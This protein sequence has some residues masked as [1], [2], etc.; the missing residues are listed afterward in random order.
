M[1]F[2]NLRRVPILVFSHIYLMDSG[3]Y[4]WGN[5][6][7]L[8]GPCQSYWLIAMYTV[9]CTLYREYGILLY[10]TVRMCNRNIQSSSALCSCCSDPGA[11][12]G[13]PASCRSSWTSPCI[14][15]KGGLGHKHGD[16]PWHSSPWEWYA[17]LPNIIYSSKLS[18]TELLFHSFWLHT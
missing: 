10:L 1:V 17:S 11:A 6:F 3:F 15:Y 13:A 2:G 14:Q 12:P 4:K 16:V 8:W 5:C 9:H 7:D 18:T